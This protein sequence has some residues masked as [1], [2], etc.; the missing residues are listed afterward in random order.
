MGRKK[1]KCWINPEW[2]C[3]V[4]GEEVPLEACKLCV[5]TRLRLAIIKRKVKANGEL[6]K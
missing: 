6:P 5:E 3:Y 2:E 1:L 4:E